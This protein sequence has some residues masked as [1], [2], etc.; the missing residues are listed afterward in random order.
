MPSAQEMSENGMSLSE[1]SNKLLEKVEELTLHLIRLEKENQRLM[2]RV[3]ELE[4]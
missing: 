2:K 4:K 1:M 3:E